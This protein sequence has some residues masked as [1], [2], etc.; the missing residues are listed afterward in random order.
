MD[1]EEIES[2]LSKAQRPTVRMHLESLAKKLKK[3]SDA[4]KRVEASQQ[5][6]AN[7]EEEEKPIVE[8]VE[9]PAVP[10]PVAPPTPA[11]S[12]ATPKASK[13][14]SIHIMP[15]A[16]YVP[17]DKFAFDSGSYNSP[18]VS[19]YI[20]LP[21]VGSI[22]RTNITTEFAVRSLDLVVR[23]LDGKSYRL[24]KNNLANDIDP[25][26]S[27]HIVKAD[28]V[29]LKLAKVKGEYGYDSWTNLVDKKK[30]GAGGSKSK[31][32]PSKNIMS[33]MKDM[34][35]S[36]DD[37]MRKVIGETMEKQRRGE[38]GGDKGGSGLG[39]MGM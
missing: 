18:T 31:D 21:K 36:G 9:R 11:P 24:L 33:M 14:A 28:K 20:S 8:E 6:K 3:E 2:L 32:D 35:D 25:A 39:D 37:Q 38:L 10:P 13:D 16:K 1:A 26:K 12:P 17:I 15:T 27:K 5:Q 34:Y 22:D 19:V 4:L 29:I 23:N 7:T 30:L